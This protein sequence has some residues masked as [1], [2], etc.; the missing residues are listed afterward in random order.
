M[1]K[2]IQRAWRAHVRYKH[3]CAAKIQH[4]WRQNKYNI[5]YLQLRDYGHQL[6]A[7]RKER[8]R[9][10]LLSQRMFIGDY[11]SVKEGTGLGKLIQTAIQIKPGEEVVFSMK[12][13]MLVP[14]AMRSSIPSPRTFVL[15]ITKEII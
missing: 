1:A 9:F 5:K 7:G 6:L 14:R 10:S 13:S 2:R 15:V 12:G 11:L 3:Q 4:Y 8:R